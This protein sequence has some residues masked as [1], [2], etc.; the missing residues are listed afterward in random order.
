MVLLNGC[1]S[2]SVSAGLGCGLGCT[3]AVSVSH[4]AATVA[5][6]VLWRCISALPLSLPLAHAPLPSKMFDCVITITQSHLKP[7][8]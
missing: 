3:P 8:A 6:C 7:T 1:R 4:S 5:I 2:K